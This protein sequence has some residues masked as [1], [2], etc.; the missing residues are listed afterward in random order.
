M[1]KLALLALPLLAS[2]SPADELLPE[3]PESWTYERIELPLPF[4]PDL[5]Y[6]GFE[7][8]RFAPG[9]FDPK[10]ASH[11]SYAFAI[12][13]EEDLRADARFIDDFLTSYY[14]G[15][16][17][18]VAPGNGLDLDLKAISTEVSFDGRVFLAT[19]RMFDAFAAGDPLTL[20]VEVS[21]H[22]GAEHTEILGI[23]SPKS[24][25]APIWKELDGV[26]ERWRAARPAAA[27]LNHLYV[28]PDAETY[29]ALVD[30]PF[31]SA[32]GVHELRTTVRTDLTYTGFYFY[33]DS[34]YFEFLSPS[35]AFPAWSTGLAF[36]FEREG[37][38]RVAAAALEG[39]EIGATVMPIT[40]GYENVQVP[41]FTMMGIQGAA[42]ADLSLFALEY[43]ARFLG[44]WHPQLAPQA[45][46]IA[47]RSVLARYAAKLEQ[48]DMRRNAPFMDVTAV[49]LALDP[50]ASKHLAEV[51]E[52]L[53]YVIEEEGD[54]LVCDGPGVTLVVRVT[55][56]SRG[57][58]GFELALREP[59]EREPI[60]FGKA[61]MSFDGATALLEFRR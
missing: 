27:F 10:S 29:A 44:R 40:R 48:E 31:L 34:T 6:E 45:G 28:V 52:T 41:W 20:R 17:E 30:S 46:G 37:G 50:A 5:E 9:M 54:A 59:L 26:R 43:D 24:R 51:C 33:G 57:V 60:E 36:G 32:F 12:R 38:A 14:R 19:I 16:C 13:F 25:E 18:A 2:A 47:R 21:V 7:E 55:H 23:A 61:R 42:S 8:L 11:F 58:T 49:H 22:A 3:T 39:R 15:L 56:I 1:I 53:G 35:A 4:A